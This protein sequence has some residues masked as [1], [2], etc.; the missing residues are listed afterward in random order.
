MWS[1]SSLEKKYSL[2]LEISK[3]H[4]EVANVLLLNFGLKKISF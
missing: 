4:F 1:K 2:C 3:I